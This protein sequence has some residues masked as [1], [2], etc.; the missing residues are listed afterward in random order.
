MRVLQHQGALQVAGTVQARG[1][2]E[3][4]IEQRARAAVHVEKLVARH[5]HVGRFHH[6]LRLTAAALPAAVRFSSN[7]FRIRRYSSAQLVSSSKPWFSTGNG[8]IDQFSL[9]SSI[10]RCVSRTLSWNS[11]LVSTIPWQISSAPFNP[12]AK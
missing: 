7:S 8:A 11:T 1:E 9:R 3:V 10:S 12:S 5:V 6:V 2:T 4:A